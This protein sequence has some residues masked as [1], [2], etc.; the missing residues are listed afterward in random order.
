MEEFIQDVK[1]EDIP[2]MYQRIV[3]AIGVESFVRLAMIT[4][5]L[6]IYIP[7]ADTLVQAARDRQI[8]SKFNGSNYRELALEY[9]LSETWVRNV[10]DQDRMEKN[11]GKLFD[12]AANY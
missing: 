6:T 9:N 5:G 11:Q 1:L 4:G 2:Q 7:K 10:I 8:I 12:T 3:M